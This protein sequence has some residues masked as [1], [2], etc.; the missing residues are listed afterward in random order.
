MTKYIEKDRIKYVLESK[1][2]SR[3]EK[4]WHSTIR[5]DLQIGTDTRLH[6]GMSFFISQWPVIVKCQLNPSSTLTQ[7]E[8]NLIKAEN[9]RPSSTSYMSYGQLGDSTEVI[10][11]ND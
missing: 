6:C 2:A 10:H 11:E 4:D 3:A 1:F 8:S 5:V 7:Q 9:S